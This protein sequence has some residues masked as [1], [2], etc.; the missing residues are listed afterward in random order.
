MKLTDMEVAPPQLYGVKVGGHFGDRRVI[1]EMPREALDD[2]FRH[3]PHLTDAQRH[4]LVT[5]NLD[6]IAAA[7][8]TKCEQQAWREINRGVGSF[9]LLDFDARDLKLSDHQLAA[10]EKAQQEVAE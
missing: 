7:M 3:R 9:W 10:D 6:S 1:Y 2:Y 8:Q 4:T 5:S